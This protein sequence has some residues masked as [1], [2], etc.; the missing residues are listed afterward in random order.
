MPR[1]LP[2]RAP[3]PRSSFLRDGKPKQRNRRWTAELEAAPLIWACVGGFGHVQECW[4]EV[5]YGL[6]PTAH[7]HHGAGPPKAPPAPPGP[8]SVGPCA[9]PARWGGGAPPRSGQVTR[10]R[11]DS[12]DTAG[13]RSTGLWTRAGEMLNLRPPGAETQNRAGPL[14]RATVAQPGLIRVGYAHARPCM[15]ALSESARSRA[16]RWHCYMARLG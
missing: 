15:R 14:L 11:A 3:L 8:A 1:C 4:P 10:V 13:Q 16:S 2:R 6:A 12:E 7:G 5:G 9:L